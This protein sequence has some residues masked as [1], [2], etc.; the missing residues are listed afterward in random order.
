MFR[1][2]LIEDHDDLDSAPHMGASGFPEPF[3][4]AWMYEESLTFRDPEETALRCIEKNRTYAARTDTEKTRTYAVRTG[5][6]EFRVYFGKRRRLVVGFRR[7][8]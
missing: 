1:E 4:R 7:N 8:P 2:L 6:G 5:L 3:P